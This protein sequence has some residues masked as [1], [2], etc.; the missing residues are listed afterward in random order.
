M[1]NQDQAGLENPFDMQ[2]TQLVLAVQQEAHQQLLGRQATD[3][4]NASAPQALDTSIKLQQAESQIQHLQRCDLHHFMLQHSMYIA[5][6]HELTCTKRV[7]ITL[8]KSLQA[9]QCFFT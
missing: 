1:H 7:C 2:S 8:I 9:S 3:S 6:H 5:P 4:M